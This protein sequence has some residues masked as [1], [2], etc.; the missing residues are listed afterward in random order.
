MK[1]HLHNAPSTTSKTTHQ[2]TQGILLLVAVVLCVLPFKASL[3][4]TANNTTAATPIHS[5]EPPARPTAEEIRRRIDPLLSEA[6]VEAKAITARNA[7]AINALIQGH[8]AGVQ[9]FAEDVV[10]L[11]GKWAY[12]K[13]KLPGTPTDGHEKFIREKFAKHIFSE[14]ALKEAV[15]QAVSRQIKELQSLENELA[16]KMRSEL[17]ALT[18]DSGDAAVQPPDFEAALK[19]ICNAASWDA[20]K[21]I[22]NVVTSEIAAQITVQI[23]TRMAASSGILAIGGAS[24]TWSLGVGFVVAILVDYAWGLIDNPA[25]DIA[26]AVSKSLGELA[27]T[28][29][30]ALETECSRLASQRCEQWE[31]AAQRLIAQATQQP[32]SASLAS[33]RNP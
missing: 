12:I 29:T 20:C 8:S 13:S 5:P 2:L 31:Q 17:A 15:S 7:H 22:G 1:T 4:N 6:R 28:G 14:V 16:I 32:Q 24:S 21:G 19:E 33:V 9:N 10:S 3:F 30:D 27:R 23:L 26:K 11:S 18:P 25:A